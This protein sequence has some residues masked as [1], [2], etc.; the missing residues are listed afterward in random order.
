V[1]ENPENFGF[2]K[3]CNQGIEVATGNYILLLNND[4]ILTDK[5]LERLVACASSDPQIGL[6]G[7]MTNNIS[8]RQRDE[9]ACYSSVEEMH[10]YAQLFHQKNRGNWFDCPRIVGFCMLIK[11][12][13]V[14][15]IGLL[16]ERFGKGNYEDDDYCLRARQAGYR[17]VIAG[18]VFIHHFGS[19][20]F[21]NSTDYDALL[22]EN[23][24][25]FRDKWSDQSPTTGTDNSEKEEP[26]SENDVKVRRYLEIADQ[27]RILGEF[28]RALTNCEKALSVKPDDPK[29]LKITGAILLELGRANEAIEPL[30]KAAN[31]EPT[32]AEIHNELG[33]CFYQIGQ[34]DSA[35]AE[36]QLAINL[37]EQNVQAYSNL[38]VLFWENKDVD[39][40]INNLKKAIEINPD[41]IDAVANLALICYGVE[42]FQEAIPLLEKSLMQ[43]PRNTQMHSYL[44]DCYSKLAKT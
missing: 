40:A 10:H 24:K 8:G 26:A 34:V 19:V 29:A 2:P 15:K 36:F 6:V 18:D 32:S 4:V 44:S 31:L 28:E 23:E 17:T 14:E 16:D 7:S 20:T 11:R 42:L 37:D 12:E 41:D 33:K 13:V 39:A 30:Q 3:G 35:K 43:Q 22:K 5:W 27:Y 21:K 9:L 25:I 38:G 1:I